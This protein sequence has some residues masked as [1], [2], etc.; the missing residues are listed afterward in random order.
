MPNAPNNATVVE[1][2]TRR[3][4]ALG[5]YVDRKS[6]VAIN[7]RKHAH[8][9]V[10]AVY[11]RSIDARAKVASLRAQLAE[12]LDEVGDADATRM[13]A[14]RA[15]KAWV[16]GEFGVE[17]TEANDFGFPAPKKA[18]LTV[19]QKVLAVERGRATRK[20]RGTMGRRQKEGIRG[21][22]AAPASAPSVAPTESNAAP[23]PMEAGEYGAREGP[24]GGF[25][26]AGAKSDH[27]L[28]DG[29]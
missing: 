2:C 13:E 1:T 16:R 25:A 19:E 11:Q 3:I 6:V 17:S 22:V 18:V 8:A 9:E 10:T 7:G 26:G 28:V 27:S 23:L 12:A 24:I 15:L 20:A 4:R 14:D 29:P 21:V 5:T